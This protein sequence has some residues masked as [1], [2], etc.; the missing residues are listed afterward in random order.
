MTELFLYRPESFD[1]TVLPKNV[2]EDVLYL[3]T[4]IVRCRFQDRRLKRGWV[5]LKRRILEQALSAENVSPVIQ[6]AEKC[7]LIERKE[8]PNGNRPSYFA[9]KVS[10]RYRIKDRFSDDGCV[11]VPMTNGR[12]RRYTFRRR[13]K[14]EDEWE[15]HEGVLVD[16]RKDLLRLKMEEVPLDYLK[17]LALTAKK[18][19]DNALAAYQLSIDDISK[20]RWRFKRDDYRRLH[21]NLTNMK[22]ELR[23]FA[24]I[25]G[26]TL[27]GVDVKNSQPLFLAYLLRCLKDGEELTQKKYEYLLN[28][29]ESVF[30]N[31][32]I[33][34]SLMYSDLT[35]SDELQRF[36]S[37]TSDGT[38]YNVLMKFL[39][40]GVSRPRVK[41]LWSKYAYA[42]HWFRTKLH[43]VFEEHFP[44]IDRFICKFKSENH[45]RFA[46]FLQKLEGEFVIDLVCS[47]LKEEHAEIPLLTIHDSIVTTIGNE[48]TVETVLHE[49]FERIGMSA[50]VEQERYDK[51]I[52]TLFR[53]LEETENPTGDPAELVSADTQ[54]P[55]LTF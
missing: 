35:K 6:E 20:G 44:S 36:M 26:K 25:D 48:S 8:K 5:P 23:N 28:E 40:T 21:T 46:Q 4:T 10:I 41:T 15:K 32:S 27:V 49:E 12:L 54:I 38:F 50:R 39:G 45:K 9:N 37:S 22:S 55:A 34:S 53:K 42:K 52:E 3:Y 33:A 17:R 51:S 11:R 1:E 14:Q 47:R 31:Q 16:L 24:R 13:K 43:P 2:R 7:D 19:T 30:I 18:E 29:L